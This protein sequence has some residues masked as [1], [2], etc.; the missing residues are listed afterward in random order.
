MTT[1]NVQGIWV[2]SALDKLISE[3]KKDP[4]AVCLLFEKKQMVL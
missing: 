4:A 3:N 1:I 2:L